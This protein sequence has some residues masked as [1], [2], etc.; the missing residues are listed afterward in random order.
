MSLA[1]TTPLPTPMTRPRTL[2]WSR[3]NSNVG[4]LVP[5]VIKLSGGASILTISRLRPRPCVWLFQRCF[6]S[7]SQASRIAAH[8]YFGPFVI[9]PPP[10]E[11]VI[12]AWASI[13]L[14]DKAVPANVQRFPTLNYPTGRAARGFGS[15]PLGPLNWANWDEQKKGQ[16]CGQEE[17]QSI[18][19][20]TAGQS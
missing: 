12:Q 3:Q 15:A 8:E 19:E 6:A 16:I 13:G 5:R 20:R 9:D 14:P 2:F 11:S 18:V 1:T 4:D 7:L 10:L 17:K